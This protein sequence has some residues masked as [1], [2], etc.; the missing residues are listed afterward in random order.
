MNIEDIN[1]K[2]EELLGIK[3]IENNTQNTDY[4][5]ESQREID[6]NASELIIVAKVCAQYISYPIDLNLLNDAREK[7]EYLI[8]ILCPYT[9]LP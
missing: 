2:N 6:N 9:H 7:A 5:S 4:E 1:R 3:P 8:D